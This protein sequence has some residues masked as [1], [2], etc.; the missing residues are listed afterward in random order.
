M[1]EEKRLKKSIWDPEINFWDCTS[2]TDTAVEYKKLYR[3]AA[4]VIKWNAG[5]IEYRIY[6]RSANEWRTVMLF[7]GKLYKTARLEQGIMQVHMQKGNL[8][9]AI[10]N[11]L[12]Q[13]Q[14][15]AEDKDIFFK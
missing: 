6:E 12:G 14:K 2:I 1:G 13:I 3:I 8:V 4:R 7:G 9:E 11:A 15:K 5:N 10:L